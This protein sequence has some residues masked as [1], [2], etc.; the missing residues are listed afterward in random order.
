[1]PLYVAWHNL[2]FPHQKCC[3]VSNLNPAFPCE[4][5]FPINAQAPEGAAYPL[6]A[7]GKPGLTFGFWEK[8][9]SNTHFFPLEVKACQL[10]QS[11]QLPPSNGCRGKKTCRR[12]HTLCPSHSWFILLSF[13]SSPYPI[14][15]HP[16]LFFFF[17]GATTASTSSPFS[18]ISSVAD[19]TYWL[20]ELLGN[21]QNGSSDF[22]M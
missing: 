13:T 11:Q 1:M 18:L 16:Y 5:L 9:P 19:A 4:K 21:P 14:C 17:L 8:G 22:A 10:G 12:M 6:A 20:L 3:L 7:A 15:H 2:H